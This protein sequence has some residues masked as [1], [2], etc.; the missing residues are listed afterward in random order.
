MQIDGMEEDFKMSGRERFPTV[1]RFPPRQQREKPNFTPM[2]N[3]ISEILKEICTRDFFVLPTP[4]CTPVKK[5]DQS[6]FCD[7]HASIGNFT[8]ECTSLKNFLERL[9][10][11]GQFDEYVGPLRENDLP[12]PEPRAKDAQL[13]HVTD[14][15]VGGEIPNREVM[16]LKTSLPTFRWKNS[17]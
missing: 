12:K 13:R 5:R 11:K 8:E 9:V 4:M 6:H 2:N 3:S 16:H 1:R 14:M 15:I 17:E 10:K 7:Y